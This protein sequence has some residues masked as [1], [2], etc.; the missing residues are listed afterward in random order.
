[1]SVLHTV[2]PT[3]SLPGTT[4]YCVPVCTLGVHIKPT[5]YCRLIFAFANK[6]N[7][8]AGDIH[9]LTVDKP[10]FFLIYRLESDDLEVEML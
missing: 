5:T 2:Q 8:A 3:F 6:G 4:V 10:S 7:V 9:L 1:M